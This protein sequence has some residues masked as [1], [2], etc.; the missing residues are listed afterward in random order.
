MA[1]KIFNSLPIDIKNETQNIKL[2]RAKLKK[3]LI[4]HAFYSVGEFMTFNNAS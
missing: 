4:S 2:F 3:Y 1:V